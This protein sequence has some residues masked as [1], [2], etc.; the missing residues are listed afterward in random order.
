MLVPRKA[1]I[2]ILLAAL[3]NDIVSSAAK[4]V[5]LAPIRVTDAEP[6]KSFCSENLSA[7]KLPISTGSSKVRKS[8]SVERFRVKFVR[9]GP[10][11]SAMKS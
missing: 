1:F 8:C 6:A 4:L 3:P 10:V 7:T 9:L 11:V 5:A 2:F